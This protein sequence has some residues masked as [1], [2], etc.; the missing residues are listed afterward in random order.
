MPATRKRGAPSVTGSDEARRPLAS[1]G[2]L[3]PLLAFYTVGLA[4]DRPHLAAAADRLLRSMLETLG[5]TGPAAPAVIVVAVLLVWHVVRGDPWRVRPRTLAAMTAWAL[6][7]TVPLV[8]LHALF[9][10]MAGSGGARLAVAEVIDGPNGWLETV[11]AA[12]GT[13]IYEELIFRLALVSAMVALAR[14]VLRLRGDGAVV[15]GVLMAAAVFAGAHTVH[16]PSAFTWPSFLFRTTAG[17]YLSYVFA[18]HGFGV[19][20]GVH[21]LFNLVAQAM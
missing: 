10:A 19:A 3:A 7:L 1:L 13:G 9:Q 16:D 18:A 11:L 15:A 21:V 20:V 12:I 6:L 2:L 17:I 8:G 5:L 4:W 14:Y